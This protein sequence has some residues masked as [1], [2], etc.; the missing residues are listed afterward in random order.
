MHKNMERFVQVLFIKEPPYV[1]SVMKH[2][3]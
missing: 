3:S 1:M 2:E